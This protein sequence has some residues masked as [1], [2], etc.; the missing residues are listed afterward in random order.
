MTLKQV[1]LM[2][3]HLQAPLKLCWPTTSISGL[4]VMTS[5]GEM[6]FIGFRFVRCL[7][8]LLSEIFEVL[9]LNLFWIKL[10]TISIFLQTGHCS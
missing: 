9:V 8:I 6:L 3:F 10:L 2:T 5:A 1:H 4:L 7:T